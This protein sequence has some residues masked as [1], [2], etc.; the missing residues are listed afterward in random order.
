MLL[1]VCVFFFLLLLFDDLRV[2]WFDQLVTEKS[3][4]FPS[5]PLR[6]L[7]LKLDKQFENEPLKLADY[8]R[9]YIQIFF[10]LPSTTAFFKSYMYLH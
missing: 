7:D 9:Q 4:S 3:H 6:V 2:F 5:R 1:Q 10:S 8:K